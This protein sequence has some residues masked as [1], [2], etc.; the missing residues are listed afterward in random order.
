MKYSVHDFILASVEITK[1]GRKR[2]LIGKLKEGS[3]VEVMDFEI[4]AIDESSQTYKLIT[5]DID[6]WII[7][8]FHLKH[9]DVDEKYLG[10]RFYDL[11]ESLVLGKTKKK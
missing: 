4:V 8:K 6:G 3:T 2:F 10:R 11:S 1:D 9:Q 7:S 5:E